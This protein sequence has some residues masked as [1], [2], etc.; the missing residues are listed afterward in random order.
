V[1]HYIGTFW[2]ILDQPSSRFSLEFYKNLLSGLGVGEATRLAR[3]ALIRE[4][5]EE[6]IVW[7]SYILYGDP[8]FSYLAQAEAAKEEE[9]PRRV[10]TSLAG[11]EVRAREEVID[12]AEKGVTRRRRTWWAAA[13]GVIVALA[14]LL[15]A[16]RLFS[17]RQI[18]RYEKEALASYSEGNFEQALSACRVLEE[19]RPNGR[20]AHL[21][22]GNI[23]LR[24][25]TLEQAEAAFQGALKAGDGTRQ[26]KAE[27]YIGLGRIASLRKQPEESLN[28]YRQ[29]TEAAP[30]GSQGYLSQAALLEGQ[31]DYGGALALLLKA[32]KLAPEDRNVA[33]L[34]RNTRERAAFM[35]DQER[36]ARVDQAVK[37]LLE[38]MKA[39]PRALPSDGWT[40]SPLTLWVMD[41]E[42][43]GFAWREGEE[44]LLV[45]GIVD[46]VIGKSRVQVVERG[47]LDKLL[48]EL[49]LGTSD[50]SERS[51]ALNVGRIVA[52]RLIVSGQVVYAGPLTQV[53]M[54][55]IE[56]ETGRITATVN[57]SF[58]SAVPASEVADRLGEKLLEKVGGLYP[59]RGKVSGVTAQ[60][61]KLNIGQRVGVATGQLFKVVNEDVTL[62][63]TAVQA[64]TSLG[65]ISKGGGPLIE[66]L[67]VEA[68]PN[69]ASQKSET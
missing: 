47:I 18:A 59:L 20:L 26:Q 53:S 23:Y 42:T 46:Q 52:A 65:T 4:Y 61:V 19:K 43:Q 38:R 39:P 64:D 60:G 67:R 15:G 31:G 63:V 69:A 2:E 58:G 37:E 51:T 17:N 33:A 28:Y 35:Q 11:A 21:I 14:V 3:Q 57:E 5:G 40:S 13:A 30:E 7:A 22:E 32:Q 12:L 6:T 1:R 55:L 41:F 34:T 44:R 56:T 68:V 9:E 36:Q 66:G 45:S 24:K 25:G 48:R 50:L 16:Y 27:A 49:K 54:R 62:T 29:A 10:H 8:T